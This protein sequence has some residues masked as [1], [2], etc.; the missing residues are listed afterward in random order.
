VK[1]DAQKIEILCTEPVA[2]STRSQDRLRQ[3]QRF[4]YPM[5][6]QSYQPLLGSQGKLLDYFLEMAE[7][8]LTHSLSLHVWFEED[9]AQSRLFGC[10]PRDCRAL[11]ALAVTHEPVPAPEAAPLLDEQ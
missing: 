1:V 8:A 2:L 5:V 4:A 6:T 3:V 9:S 11:V 7:H 10:D